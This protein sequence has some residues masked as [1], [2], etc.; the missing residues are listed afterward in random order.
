MIVIYD[1]PVVFERARQLIA[2]LSQTLEAGRP[3]QME[4]WHFA[5]LDQDWH[6]SRL[7][8]S[9]KNAEMIVVAASATR[10]L[11]E[12][13]EME[14]RLWLE[15]TN[16]GSRAMLA[17]LE[18]SSPDARRNGL[19]FERLQSLASRHGADFFVHLADPAPYPAMPHLEDIERNTNQAD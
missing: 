17:F 1:Q 11:P 16:S 14:V 15:L 6:I 5:S 10:P 9:M 18:G 3:I 7:R 13:V 8:K 4:A 12:T 19:P 2:G